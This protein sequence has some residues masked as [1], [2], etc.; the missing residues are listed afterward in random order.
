M[1]YILIFF[2]VNQAKDLTETKLL[3]YVQEERLQTWRQIMEELELMP[4]DFTIDYSEYLPHPFIL[5]DT[6]EGDDEDDPDD[7]DDFDDMDDDFDDDFDDDDDDY[8]YEED[9]DYDDFD[10]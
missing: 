4:S 2:S 5:G 3:P 1:D 7:G 9:V 10:E 8:D 6:E